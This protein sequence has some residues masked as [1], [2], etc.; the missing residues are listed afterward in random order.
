MGEALYSVARQFKGLT[1]TTGSPEPD[2]Y[3]GTVAFTT[4]EAQSFFVIAGAALAASF[5]RLG[6]MIAAKAAPTGT[7]HGLCVSAVNRS[8]E[9]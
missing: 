1:R 2:Y 8:I 3:R 6:L 4:A 9:M 5:L 7:P